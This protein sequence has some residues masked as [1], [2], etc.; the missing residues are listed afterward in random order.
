M[1][2][3]LP[4]FRLIEVNRQQESLHVLLC[5]EKGGFSNADQNEETEA[6]ARL[7]QDAIQLLNKLH[8]K[9]T[10]CTL[11]GE[12]QGFPVGDELVN[13]QAD[14]ELTVWY[15]GTDFGHPWVVL[16]TAVSEQEFWREVTEDDDLIVLGP[17]R[18]I[19][20]VK[21]YCARCYAT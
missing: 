2:A 12:L 16:G 17:R 6:S 8:I 14:T 18:P 1:A 3:P 11:V 20:S 10:E 19:K 21:A 9:R 13:L 4:V 5:L 15:A 7:E